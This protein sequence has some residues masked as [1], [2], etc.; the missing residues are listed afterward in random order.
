[1]ER[2]GTSRSS[3]RRDK[4]DLVDALWARRKCPPPALLSGGD[5]AGRSSPAEIVTQ[6]S[7]LLQGVATQESVSVLSAAGWTVTMI[8]EATA[9]T[10]KSTP[11][12]RWDR[13]VVVSWRGM[14]ETIVFD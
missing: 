7:P 11:D 2:T 1:M 4:P 5:D 9:T 8:V 6:L 13:L 14:V 10:T 12:V 3:P